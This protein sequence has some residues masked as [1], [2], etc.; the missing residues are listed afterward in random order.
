[1]ETLTGCHERAFPAFGGAPKEVPHDNMKTVVIDRDAHGPGKRR[2]HAALRDL[3]GHCGFRSRLRRPYR[4]QTKG[5]VERFV[6][7]LRG[8]SYV[9]FASRMA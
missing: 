6:R 5:K 9:P 4:A 3:A 2:F 8:S 1:V 7:Y